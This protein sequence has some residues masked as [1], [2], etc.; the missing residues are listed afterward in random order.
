MDC[1]WP[2]DWQTSRQIDVAIHGA[3]LLEWLKI[4]AKIVSIAQY[5][6]TLATTW[7]VLRKS[8][9]SKEIFTGDC[10]RFKHEFWVLTC[11]SIPLGKS[12]SVLLDPYV[13]KTAAFSSGVP[14]GSI[15]GPL[16]LFAF[17]VLN[18]YYYYL[19]VSL[20]C[21]IRT[22]W[23]SVFCSWRQSSLSLQI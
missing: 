20:I 11:P 7:E 16:L 18:Y 14:Q 9:F 4:N 22:G 6:L 12:F 15:F 17:L 5:R 13:S 23:L 21:V 19:K 8:Q 2:T 3:M 10:S 1:E